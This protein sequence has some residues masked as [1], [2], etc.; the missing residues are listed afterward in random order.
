MNWPVIEYT[1]ITK[2][3]EERARRKKIERTSWEEK[4]WLEKKFGQSIYDHDIVAVEAFMLIESII[5]LYE[6]VKSKET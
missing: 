4:Y 6:E 3:R 1:R 5:G 2:T